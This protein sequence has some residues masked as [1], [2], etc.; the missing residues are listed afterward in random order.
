MKKFVIIFLVSIVSI[1][2]GFGKPILAAIPEVVL[3]ANDAK[4]LKGGVKIVDDNDASIKKAIEISTDPNNPLIPNPPT[5][6]EMEF[7]ADAD[8]YYVWARGKTDFDTGTDSFWIQFDDEIGTDKGKRHVDRGLGNWLDVYK[9]GKYWWG[10]NLVPPQT[11]EFVVLSKAGKHKL[12]VQPRQVVHRIDQIYLSTTQDKDWT[13]MKDDP[14]LH[15]PRPKPQ[16]VS[17]K[18]KLATF[19]GQIKR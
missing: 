7:Q 13:N 8:K 1:V 9:A 17:P 6:F 16:A 10:S 19:W 14:A 15:K 2:V 5:Y 18:A 11:V 3:D 4:L 12:R